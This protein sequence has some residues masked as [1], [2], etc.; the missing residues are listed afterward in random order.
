MSLR[1][2]TLSLGL[3]AAGPAVAGLAVCNDTTELHSVAIGYKSG[4]GWLSQGWWNIEPD[5]CVTVLAGDLVNRYYYL[6]AKADEWSFDHEGIGFCI[7][8]DVFDIAG[9]QDCSGRGYGQ[10][11]FLELDTGKTEKDH[12]TY[13]A[14]VSRPTAP[15]EPA[16]VPPGK[17]GEPYSAA[18]NFQ[19]CKTDRGQ[20]VC[21]I[22]A[23]GVQ[24]FFRQDGREGEEAFA[25]VERFRP[26]SPVIVH[27]DLEAIHD[28]T[29]DLV[30]YKLFARGWED[31][32]DLLQDMQGQWQSRDDAAAGLTL[33]GSLLDLTYD[34]QVVDSAS[35]RV[36][37]TCNDFSEGGPYLTVRFG[38]E[39]EATCYGDVKIDGPFLNMIHLPRGN[40]LR[41]LRVD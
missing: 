21:S 6:M 38:G 40:E 4:E 31:A 25:F 8:A 11:Q 3:M 13:L 29:A 2:F 34:T 24:I 30:P 20:Q 5:Q 39:P 15:R 16:Y 26:G 33:T 7:L 19:S 32:D 18:G 35:I 22:F 10:G 9:D 36:S 41:Y 28:S 14:T 23:D 1:A 17:H 37:A 27:G 12:V